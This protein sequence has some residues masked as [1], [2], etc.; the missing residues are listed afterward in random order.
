MGIPCVVNTRTGTQQLH[1]G[2]LVRVDGTQGTVEILQP[3]TDNNTARGLR[4]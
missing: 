4:R 2:D 3:Q 1:T